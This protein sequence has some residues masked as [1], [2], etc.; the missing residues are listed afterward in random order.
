LRIREILAY[1]YEKKGL[2]FPAKSIE[3]TFEDLVRQSAKIF[4][5]KTVI[6]IDEYDK[7]IL[8]NI[9]NPAAAAEMREGLKNLY[10]VI[11]DCD[12]D[13]RF[14]FLTGV[15]KFSKVSIFSGLN[16]LT[17]IT[18]APAFSA[19][20]GY[21]ENDLDEVFAP[22][23]PGADRQKIREW[24]NGYNWLGQ[25]VYNPY[26]ILL[27]FRNRE[28]GSYW[29]ESG[30]PTFLIKLLLSRRAWIPQFDEFLTTEKILSAFDVD[31][32]STEALM[33][34][35]GY[36]T[37]KNFTRLPGRTEILLGYP[38]KEVKTSLNQHLL[39]SLPGDRANP[40]PSVSKATYN[41]A[42]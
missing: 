2:P 17:D 40:T 24:Y 5:Q 15:S 16:N 42:P 9:E 22:E 33:F 37:I 11:K 26:D 6:L 30:T 31:H 35:A 41:L 34:Q 28:F 36:L 29:F 27:F 14:A 32:I 10:S 18:L 13:I 39:P 25:P 20:C 4:G 7:P 1:E 21:T 23:L 38:N 8:D 3:G 19:I 12:A